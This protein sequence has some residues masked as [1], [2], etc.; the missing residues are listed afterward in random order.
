MDFT[1]CQVLLLFSTGGA[2]IC[3]AY[4]VVHE[5]VFPAHFVGQCKF[6]AAPAYPATG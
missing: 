6:A 4:Q 1:I 5:S 3:A 2:N